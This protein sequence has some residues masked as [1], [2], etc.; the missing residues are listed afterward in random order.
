MSYIHKF[1]RYDIIDMFNY[2]SR[3]LDDLLTI[4]DPEFEKHILDIYLTDF[5]FNQANTSNKE[6]SFLDLRI[7]VIGSDIHTSI[8][9][10][11]ITSNFLLS[12]S[13]LVECLCS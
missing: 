1:V 3:Y 2:T 9:T 5:Q 6:T 7:Q 4:D 11:A 12:I 13:P 10:N 8:T